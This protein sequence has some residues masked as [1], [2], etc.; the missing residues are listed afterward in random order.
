MIAAGV[1]GDSH[2]KKSV[3]GKIERRLL[4]GAKADLA[5]GYVDAAGIR[6]RAADQGGIAAA[7]DADGAGVGNA[8]GGTVAAEGELPALEVGIGYTERGGH[9]AATGVDRT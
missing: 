8:S 9:E 5:Q 7:P 1:G 4:T 6:N 2:L 3:A